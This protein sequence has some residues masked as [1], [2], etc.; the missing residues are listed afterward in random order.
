MPHGFANCKQKNDDG[1]GR[2]SKSDQDG[3]SKE[4]GKSRSIY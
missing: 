2:S 1:T 4:T 3:R